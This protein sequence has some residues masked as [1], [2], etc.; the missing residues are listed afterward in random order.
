MSEVFDLTIIGGGPGGY[1]CG[2][3]AAQLGMKVALIEK[4]ETL[5]G[6]CVNV[7]CIPSK[8]LLDSSHKFDEIQHDMA[9]HGIDVKGAKMDVKKMMERKVGVVKEL[10]D[11][12]NF[13][14]NKN[15]IKVFRGHGVF[16]SAAPGDI[17]VKVEGQDAGVVQ[18]KNVVVATGSEIIQ[19]PHIA[20]DGDSII[21]SDEAIAL[22]KVPQHM[23]IIGAGI[24]GLELGSVWARLGAKVTLVEML[25]AILMP[26]DKSM[27]DQTRRIFEKQG[28]EI[29]L[30]TKVTGAAKSGKDVKVS[31][32]DK[33]GKASEIKCDKLLVAVGRKPYTEN[34][35]L[36]KVGVKLND[37]GRIA[38]D[39]KLNTGVPGIFA[40]GDV[41]EGAMLAH[42]AE[43]EGVMVAENLAGKAGHV[44]YDKIPGVVYTAPEIAW[45]GINAD[46]AKEKGITAKVGKFFFKPN[47]RAKAM[48]V[49]D[50]QIKIVTDAGTD[51]VLGAQIIGP[52]AADLL[53]EVVLCMEF[54]G[55]AEDIGRASHSHPTLS[56]VMKE[57]ALGAYDKPIHA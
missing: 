15:K 36:D 39:A 11:G 14:M 50:G 1:V 46:E 8:A 54:G 57:A 56:E 55:S 16:E 30:E 38:V 23:V 52:S 32:E 45:V 9:D 43:E 3:R 22:D 19:L 42:K 41:I 2:I 7:G 12:L 26:L 53:A 49:Q 37:R 48:G 13:L 31:I 47:G 18:S 20:T 40:I 5:G 17:K 27:R 24:I 51:K 34:L 29:L 28:L 10:T 35:G 21:T 44:S 4:R 6:T 25:P 33:A